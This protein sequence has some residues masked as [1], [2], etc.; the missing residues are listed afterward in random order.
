MKC[1]SCKTAIDASKVV[2]RKCPVCKGDVG[3][4]YRYP[5]RPRQKG[6]IKRMRHEMAAANSAA[7]HFTGG[8]F[9]RDGFCS[10]AGVNASG[11][12]CRACLK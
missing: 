2:N 8:K 5:A 11:T 12:T 6:K 3:K 1:K 7:C 4:K 9:N 10:K